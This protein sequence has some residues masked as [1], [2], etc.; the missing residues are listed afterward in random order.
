MPPP[1]LPARVPR[2]CQGRCK[3][4]AT[5]ISVHVYTD[6]PCNIKGIAGEKPATRAGGAKGQGANPT[7]GPPPKA[8][9]ILALLYTYYFALP[10][11]FPRKHPPYKTKSRPPHPLYIFQTLTPTPACGKRPPLMG[12]RPPAI[13]RHPPPSGVTRIVSSF[14]RCWRAGPHFTCNPY[15][16]IDKV[17]IPQT[18][19]CAY[20][21]S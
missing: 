2:D 17:C 14:A 8:Q 11:T 13:C 12:P 7:G 9:E 15:A 4:G 10:I 1:P 18:G 20:V 5:P 16:P 21:Q 19:R 6:F 3:A